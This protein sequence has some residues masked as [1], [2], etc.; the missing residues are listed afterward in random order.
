[1]SSTA[2]MLSAPLP[3]SVATLPPLPPLPQSRPLLPQNPS[4]PRPLPAQPNVV[5]WPKLRSQKFVPA[6]MFWKCHPNSTRQASSSPRSHFSIPCTKDPTVASRARPLVTLLLL[7]LLRLHRFRRHLL[8]WHPMMK[9]LSRWTMI[10]AHPVITSTSS[11]L[12]LPS[13]SMV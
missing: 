9:V 12:I 7:Q 13:S 8:R 11:T 4:L 10:S 6:E 1:M 2:T 5:L 3:S